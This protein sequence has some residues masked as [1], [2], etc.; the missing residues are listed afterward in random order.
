MLYFITVLFY[1]DV[2]LLD[3]VKDKIRIPDTIKDNNPVL[4]C[5]YTVWTTLY[6]SQ[7]KCL[8]D[9]GIVPQPRQR[10]STKFNQPFRFLF[11][12]IEKIW[13]NLLILVSQ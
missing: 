10:C 2:D 5:V 7:I 6:V 9:T 4:L 13:R 3:D 8:F 1:V 12:Y 11:L